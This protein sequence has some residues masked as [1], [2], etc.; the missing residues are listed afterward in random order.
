MFKNPEWFQWFGGTKRD[1]SYVRQRCLAHHFRQPIL[2]ALRAHFI[3][4]QLHLQASGMFPDNAHRHAKAARS[5]KP[6][7]A[8]KRHIFHFTGKQRVF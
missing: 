1:F 2:L 5:C 3:H 7:S 4:S 6:G 8:W